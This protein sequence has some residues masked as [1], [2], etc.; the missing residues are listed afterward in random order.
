MR[1]AF[2]ARILA[3]PYTGI[4][5][6]LEHLVRE[7]VR[8]GRHELI[9]LSDRPPRPE[10]QALATLVPMAVFGERARR[11]W[12]HHALSWYLRRHRVDVYHA[13]AGDG[14][15]WW[16]PCPSL[17]TWHDLTPLIQPRYFGRW[18]KRFTYHISHMIERRIARF[19]I[20]NSEYTRGM[21]LRHFPALAS[22]VRVIPL[23]V[24]AAF[25]PQP[26]TPARRQ[27]LVRCGLNHR[28]FI[29]SVPSRL[30][31]PRKNVRRMLEAYGTLRTHLKSPIDLVLV[32]SDL[33]RPEAR[34]ELLNSCPSPWRADIHIF[35]SVAQEELITL[36][37]AARVCCYPSL[38][39]GFGLPLLE[40]MACGTP[41]VASNT[42]CLPEIAGEAAV[43]VNP[44]DVEALGQALA[45]VV[46]DDAL[47]QEL[48][49]RGLAHA[50]RYSWARTAE[51][52]V[53][54]YEEAVGHH[55]R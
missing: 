44:T 23:G 7:L 32:G 26:D 2:D 9:L 20:T 55:R 17:L 42:S 53:A 1:I 40:S 47:H 21:I 18:K 13:V 35:D 34:A 46:T 48:A 27:V 33:G 54:L 29:L 16:A 50:R 43:L 25:Q 10:Q 52:T 15:P 28:P 6:Y 41:V 49:T 3:R 24:S 37:A 38:L 11:W 12:P 30:V 31:E 5:A 19:L 22:K 36:Y 4:N 51:E 8:H 45:R 39:E 14:I